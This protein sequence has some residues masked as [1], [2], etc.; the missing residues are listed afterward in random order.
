MIAQLIATLRA[1]FDRTFAD[2]RKPMTDAEMDAMDRYDAGV[3]AYVAEHLAARIAREW[4]DDEA[5]E[6]AWRS[7]TH[8]PHRADW[9]LIVHAVQ[10]GDTADAGRL[11]SIALR[12]RIAE[13]ADD[14][15]RDEYQP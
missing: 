7:L 2:M 11:L 3:D 10:F 15:L 13:R 5:H 4:H 6:A 8:K 1:D 14:Q 12:A 9:T